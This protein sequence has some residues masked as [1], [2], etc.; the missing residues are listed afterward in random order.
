[1]EK[2]DIVTLKTSNCLVARQKRNDILLK[3]KNWI[4]HSIKYTGSNEVTQWAAAK[5]ER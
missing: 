4:N 3:T 1:V 2:A 5:G